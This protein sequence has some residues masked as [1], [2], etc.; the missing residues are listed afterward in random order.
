MRIAG[1]EYNINHKALEI[2]ISG[3]DGACK[4]CHNE[5]LWDFKIGYH[6]NEFD[7]HKITNLMIEHVWVMGGEPLL[8]DKKE[9]KS[10]IYNI[11][12]YTNT[13]K[14]IWLWTRFDIND[15]PNNILQFLSYVKIGKYIEFSNS[16]IEPLFNIELASDNQ[17]IIKVQ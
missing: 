2:Y 17:K 15:I 14:S 1:T 7:F 13:K 10:F 12:K 8:Q 11:N 4:G 6:W 16:Y 5:S 9:L 3:C